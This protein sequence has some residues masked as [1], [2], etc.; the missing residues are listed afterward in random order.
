MYK[1]FI[2]L[3]FALLFVGALPTRTEKHRG[4]LRSDHGLHRPLR[5]P[6]RAYGSS[7]SKRTSHSASTHQFERRSSGAHPQ[8]APHSNVNEQHR[9]T[10]K[11]GTVVVTRS[12]FGD[13]KTLQRDSTEQAFEH[14]SD[15]QLSYLLKKCLGNGTKLANASRSEKIKRLRQLVKTNGRQILSNISKLTSD[16]NHLRRTTVTSPTMKPTRPPHYRKQKPPK[17]KS[18]PPQSTTT[19]EETSE[20]TTAT[21]PE[22]TTE[23]TP[24]ST[25]QTTPES[26]TETTPES[27][28][29]TE[30]E[31]TDAESIAESEQ[32]FGPQFDSNSL[33][34][35]LVPLRRP[36]KHN[37]TAKSEQTQKESS[38]KTSKEKRLKV[39]FSTLAQ[40]KA[41]YDKLRKEYLK[42]YEQIKTNNITD[43]KHSVLRGSRTSIEKS[44]K[45]FNKTELL[46]NLK[47]LARLSGVL[48]NLIKKEQKKVKGHP[49]LHSSK[50]VD[51]AARILNVDKVKG[52]KHNRNRNRAKSSSLITSKAP[53]GII[54]VGRSLKQRRKND[55]K[56]DSSAVR[57]APFKSTRIYKKNHTT[58]SHSSTGK[59]RPHHLNKDSSKRADNSKKSARVQNAA[60]IAESPMEDLRADRRE[61]KRKHLN[62]HKSHKES[63]SQSHRTSKKKATQQKVTKTN[64]RHG[65][66]DEIKQGELSHLISSRKESHDGVKSKTTHRRPTAQKPKLESSSEESAPSKPSKPE[67]S[68]TSD[69]SA[70]SEINSATATD[71]RDMSIMELMMKLKQEYAEMNAPR[72]QPIP[73]ALLEDDGNDGG[74]L[75]KSEMSINSSRIAVH[76]SQQ[77]KSS[78]TTSKKVVH[79][80]VEK[81]S[82]EDNGEEEEEAEEVGSEVTTTPHDDNT[83]VEE[84]S[85]HVRSRTEGKSGEANTRVEETSKAEQSEAEETS[86][87]DNDMVQKS[88]EEDRSS[89]TKE[90]CEMVQCD[91]EEGSL[92]SY[93]STKD[94]VSPSSKHYKQRARQRRGA[95]MTRRSWHNWRGR[96]R[97]HLTGIAHARIFGKKNKRFAAAYV[98]PKQW[99]ALT[100]KLLSGQSETIRFRAW[101][102]TSGVQLR[103]CCDS[104]KM[105]PF[106]SELGVSKKNRNWIEHSATCPQGTSKVSIKAHVALITSIWPTNRAP[107]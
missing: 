54:T 47:R 65:S 70:F 33:R 73:K 11:N 64:R 12:V 88:S 94:D 34:E 69:P 46:N 53:N 89:R 81:T 30:I 35:S 6:H 92:C 55:H 38:K 15:S 2:A 24:E 99:A 104:F 42:L 25:T 75:S 39:L 60:K 78:R 57:P 48:S 1:H 79:K 80:K 41:K 74:A 37:E 14:L 29:T 56:T 52:G 32:Y 67:S 100:T 40:V 61:N 8:L 96:Y 59:H 106:V 63:V 49:K 98:K 83:D 10:R 20:S 58:A 31:T 97:N 107:L 43:S 72:A 95:H 27:T 82:R 76:K 3:L 21:T 7:V 85:E 103:V 13:S 36:T 9:K 84:N 19:T 77:K 50:S 22:S 17:T 71:N 28:I 66:R 16:T 90:A 68:E 18:T 45:H 91:F 23:T 62:N 101:E 102:A 5:A 4:E 26:T 87:M 93:K 44:K 105:C 86:D 51:A